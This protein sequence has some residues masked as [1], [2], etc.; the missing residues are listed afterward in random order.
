MV[1][2]IW[3]DLWG[4]V[5]RN[6]V[7]MCFFLNLFF[8][9]LCLPFVHTFYFHS[10]L[11]PTGSLQA[12]HHKC[13]EKFHFSKPLFIHL[14]SNVLPMYL[15]QANIYFFFL[16]FLYDFPMWSYIKPVACNVKCLSYWNALCVQ[17]Y[18]LDSCLFTRMCLHVVD[19]CFL[20]IMFSWWC[21]Y[22]KMCTQLPK[23]CIVVFENLSLWEYALF[24]TE[25]FSCICY[26]HLLKM[27]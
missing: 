3:Y 5:L 18:I 1:L 11:D 4:S 14:K 27:F 22:L 16:P 7:L 24:L 12:K 19:L 17:S 10:C 9:F 25:T 21:L 23:I 2:E 13:W 15:K 8:F 6:F 20:M 26:L